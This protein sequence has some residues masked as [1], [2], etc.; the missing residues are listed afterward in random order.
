MACLTTQ[1]NEQKLHLKN[2]FAVSLLLYW[3]TVNATVDNYFILLNILKNALLL[4]L[5]YF[6]QIQ[7]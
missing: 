2:G 1:K 5:I 6:G 4:F 7:T 3:F